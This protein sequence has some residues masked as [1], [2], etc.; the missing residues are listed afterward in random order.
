[1]IQSLNLLLLV[2]LV[3]FCSYLPPWALLSSPDFFHHFLLFLKEKV[4][5]DRN[6]MFLFKA[7]DVLKAKDWACLYFRRLKLSSTAVMF[8]A[9]KLI[10]TILPEQV[11]FD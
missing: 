7:L 10:F 9:P 8:F 11:N 1:M 3:I 2:S 6:D 4:K 5:K